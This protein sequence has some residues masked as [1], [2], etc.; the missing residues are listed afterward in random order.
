MGLLTLPHR[1][2]AGPEAPG[3]PYPFLPA[4]R[5]HHRFGR[6]RRR[7]IY[8]NFAEDWRR[9]FTVSVDRKA[10]SAFAAAGIDLKALTGKR[11]RARGFLAWRNGPVIEASHPEQIELLA[12][13]PEATKAAASADGAGYRS[14]GQ[15]VP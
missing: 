3:A 8:L 10:A 13:R 12:G 9:D 4:G 11:L 7:P 5:R 6:R 2:R 14:I 1:E 15:A